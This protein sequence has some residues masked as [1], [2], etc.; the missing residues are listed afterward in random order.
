[1]HLKLV[2]LVAVAL[3]A[4]PAAISPSPP[5]S[6]ASR[7]RSSTT[8][9][10]V[11]L[12]ASATAVAAGASA[13][14]YFYGRGGG[15]T[16]D[17][18]W[19]WA[20]F[21]M[22][23]EALLERGGDAQYRQWLT[24]WGE[25]A[26]WT[27]SSVTSPTS[28]PDTRASIQVWH[29]M[30]AQGV[31]ADLRPSDRVMEADLDIP[32][33]TY[34]W[35]DS[36]FMGL[37]LWTQ[38]SARTGDPAYAAKGASFYAY[39]KDQGRTT[40]RPGCAG[41]GLFDAT[42][43]LWW[44]DC[45]YVGKTDATGT[46]EFWGRGNGWVIAAMARTLMAM[47]PTDPARAEYESML[48][49]MSARLA[50]LQGADGLWRSNL[51]NPSAYP[52]AETSASALIAYAMAYG[53][54]T[55]LLDRGTYLPVVARAWQGLATTSLRPNGFVSNC[56]GVGEA[57]AAPSTT[58]S[59][60]YCVGAVA[61]AAAEV[62]RLSEQEAQLVA[63]DTFSRTTT[64]GLGSADT[65][66]SW[67][68]GGPAADFGVGG[69]VARLTTPRGQTRTAFL[70]GVRPATTDAA[71]TAAF[72]RPAA[73]RTYL[74]ILAR[75]TGAAHYSARAVV[76]PDGSV[77]VQVQRSGVTVE[78]AASPGL[79]YVSGDR[80]RLRLQVTGSSP[81]TVSA[82][83]WKVG[84]PEPAAWQVSMTDATAGLQGTGELGL[85]TYYSS[86]GSSTPVTVSFD[87]LVARTSQPLSVVA[88]NVP[89]TR[90][91]RSS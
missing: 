6:A 39:L 77:N 7:T 83:A 81:S 5:G 41:T 19:R 72:T 91:T 44:R 52:A 38:W 64:A 40:W 24:A 80:L 49:R 9:S 12:P 48:V 90:S 89:V 45:Q 37:P 14:E 86:G 58:T 32:T 62:S 8:S 31:P 71:V 17:S 85:V 20:P 11:A 36:L 66:G 13:L 46:K 42:E 26:R 29:D 59:I 43:G 69:G 15:A 30:A 84:T 54:R 60:A 63:A 18:G 75:R 50:Q 70:D 1:M 55:G 53:V 16:A 88:P 76:A 51:L 82:K 3:A 61:L 34:W 73:G 10:A 57:P 22:G 87:E 28:N 65:G 79:T 4:V 68:T 35:V 74:A 25:R 23:A 21:F 33:A 47:G 27:P 67:V 2:S 56:Q 78:A